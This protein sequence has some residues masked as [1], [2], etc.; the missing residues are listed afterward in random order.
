MISLEVMMLVWQKEEFL[1]V[2][3][4]SILSLGI[5]VKGTVDPKS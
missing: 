5:S 1:E 4:I 2:L 3:F